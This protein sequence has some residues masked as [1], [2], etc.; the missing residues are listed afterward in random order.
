ML[1][2]LGPL[3]DDEAFELSIAH[4]LLRRAGAGELD[5]A[6]RVYRPAGPAVVFGRRD[7]RLPGYPAAVAAAHEAGFGTAVR[8]VGGRAVAYTREAVVVDHVRAEAQS[9]ASMDR[10]FEDFGRRFAA[11]FGD[12]GID[13]RVG[14][15][16]GEYCPGAH[17][18]NARDEVKLVGTAQRV[19]P[20][21]WLFSSLVNVG[22]RDR[23]SAVL[24]DVYGALDLPFDPA[25]VGTLQS[26]AGTGADEVLAAVLRAWDAD[27]QQAVEV[28][29]D[30]LDR[31]ALLEPDHRTPAVPK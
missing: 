29:R 19:L 12:L 24:A 7:T 26:E 21:A 11:L 25:S 30:T 3:G 15:V 17:S 5:E 2:H 13:A 20:R 8:A 9:P 23:V 22:D 31:A 6:L 16:P 18:V 28:D 10:R 27:P 14:P 4:A 1:L